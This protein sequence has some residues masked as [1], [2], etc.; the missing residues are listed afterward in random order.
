MKAKTWISIVGAL[1]GAAALVLAAGTANADP[2]HG[3]RG[4]PGPRPGFD[5]MDARFGHNHYYP[6]RGY[7]VRDLPR[8]RVIVGGGRYY[9]SGGIWYAPRGPRFVVVG[10]P[11]GVYVP[12]LPAYYTTVYYDGVP[13]YYANDT[14]YQWVPDQNQYEVVQLPGDENVAQTQPEPAVQAAATTVTDDIFIYPKNGQTEEQQATDK[15]ECHKWANQQSGFDPTQS[16]GG[17]PPEQNASAHA[18]YNR[19]MSACL[20]GRGY[21]VK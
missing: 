20:E 17:V 9:Y 4:G 1:A 14:Y 3:P 16:G 12:I 2:P 13:Y 19:A 15:Y 11:L 18:A 7:E 10:P 21:S 6:S 5:H 8:D